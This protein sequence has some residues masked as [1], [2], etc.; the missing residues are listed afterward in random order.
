MNLLEGPN[1]FE[2]LVKRPMI[3]LKEKQSV[4]LKRWIGLKFSV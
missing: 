3:S 1:V 4:L 2:T